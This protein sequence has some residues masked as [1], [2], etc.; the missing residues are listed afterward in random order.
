MV[1]RFKE[2]GHP[3]FRS[4]SAFSRGILKQD[5]GKRTIHFNGDSM[6]TELLFQTI[7]HVSHGAV[8][9]WCHQFGLTEKE[10]GRVSLPVDNK[11]LTVVVELLVS[12]PTQALGNRRQGNVLSFKALEKYS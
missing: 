4:T 3:V 12:P 11:M 7:H 10:K 9:D 6:N 8:T 5:K 1:Q 2:S